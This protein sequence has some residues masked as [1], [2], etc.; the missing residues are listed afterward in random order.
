ME[1]PKVPIGTLVGMV[2]VVIQGK[3]LS[4]SD[5]ELATVKSAKLLGVEYKDIPEMVLEV[6][7]LIEHIPDE[8]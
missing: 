8:G 4:Q 5:L 3:V 6:E 2:K 1:I 7:G